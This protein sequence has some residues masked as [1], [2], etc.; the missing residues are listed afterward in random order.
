MLNISFLLF[1]I[2]CILADEFNLSN[3]ASLKVWFGPKLL[4]MFT[5]SFVLVLLIMHLPETFCLIVIFIL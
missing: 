4:F 2:N 5:C 3:K 1:A